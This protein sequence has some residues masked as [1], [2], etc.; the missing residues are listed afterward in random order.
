MKVTWFDANSWLIEAAGWRVLVDPW[1]IGD[2]VFGNV[3]WLVKGVRPIDVEIPQNID[4]IL[5][6]QGLADHAHPETLSA[7]DKSIPVVASPDAAKVAKAAGYDSVSVAT[8]GDTISKEKAGCAPLEVMALQGAIVGATKRE[9]GY[10]LTFGSEVSGSEVS[11]SEVSESKT[12]G[13]KKTE[14][15]LTRLYY[16]PH[17][18]PDVNR[19]KGVGTVDVVITPLADITLVKVAPVVRGGD[20]AMQIAKLLRPQIMMPTAE[21][22]RV[23]YEGVIAGALQTDGGAEDMRSR[24]KKEGL[25]VQVV[26]PAS[27][28]TVELDLRASVAAV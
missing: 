1:L 27:G 11:G 19:L 4:L 25:A 8:H 23:H 15:A 9:N 28:E 6:S 21:E 5:L 18:Y 22:G 10:V 26:Q 14:S 20:V 24:L 17:G 3:S 7:L 13:L 16:E 2:L 12:S